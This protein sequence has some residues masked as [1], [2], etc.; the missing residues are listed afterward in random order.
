MTRMKM[1]AIGAVG[2]AMT[3]GSTASAAKSTKVTMN[4]IT[5]DGVGKSVGTITIKEAKDGVT[6]EP[7]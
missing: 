5:T 4:A 7:S 1:V 3:L 2:A 6:I